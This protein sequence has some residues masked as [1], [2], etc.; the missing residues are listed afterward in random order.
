[1]AAKTNYNVNGKNYFRV[2]ASFGRDSNGKLIRKYFYGKSEKEAKKKL[3]E[4]KDSLKKGLILDK[5]LFIY[6]LMKEWL[7]EIVR[8]RIKESTFDRYEDIF[9]NYIKTAPFAYTL[10]K[11]I[12]GIDI[13]KYYNNLYKNGKSS[14]RIQRV[15]KLLKQFFNYAYIEG[16]ILKNPV[17]NVSIPGTKEKIKKEVE[18]FD[19]DE[20][21]KILNYE[22]ED[23]IKYISI[24]AFTTGMRIGE[25]LGLSENDIDFNK[26]VI[27]INRIVACYTKIDGDTRKKVKV[28]QSPKTKYSTRDIPLPDNLIPILNK[29]KSIK[30]KNKLKAGGS[31][32]KEYSDLYFLTEDGNLIYPSNLNK[33]WKF[34]LARLD[35]PYKKFHS[36]RHT[37]ATMQF[38]SN[39]PLKTVSKLLGHSKIDITANTYT[40]VLKEDLDKSA[41]IF[42]VLKMC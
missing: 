27:H 9:R 15:N 34:F 29:V 18:I 28:L 23:L 8:N 6:P 26:K 19:K 12:R 5:D 1:M 11:D 30:L 3:E 40:H 4:Y 39:I 16:Y 17:L 31:Y 24:V 14:G 13:Q 37:Y 33:S 32:N 21:N 20:L 35:I 36:L 10:I 38:R 41:D 2:S 42:N 25:I 22:K 7:F